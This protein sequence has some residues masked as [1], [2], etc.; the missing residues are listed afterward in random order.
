MKRIMQIV[1][2]ACLAVASTG[3]GAGSPELKAR[4]QDG[5]PLTDAEKKNRDDQIKKSMERS[6][7]GGR[8]VTPKP[9]PGS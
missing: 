3:C 1:C 7:Y 9:Q 6:G 8:G 4:M 2:V 5:A